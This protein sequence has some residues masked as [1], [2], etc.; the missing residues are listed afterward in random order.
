MYTSLFETVFSDSFYS[1]MKTVYVVSESQLEEIK[2]EQRKD[3]LTNLE[4]SR[5][6][7]EELYHSR[8]KI[9]NERENELKEELKALAPA[10][11]KAD[12]T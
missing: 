11:D 1:P 12:K 2:R 10:Q 7:L 3:E 8:I 5:K 4:A 9:I 6:K